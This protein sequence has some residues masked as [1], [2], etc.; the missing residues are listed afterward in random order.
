MSKNKSAVEINH[1]DLFSGIGGFR[2]GLEQAGFGFKN[3]FHSEVD[4]YANGV[5][6]KQ[7]LQSKE[8]GDVKKIKIRIEESPIRETSAGLLLPHGRNGAAGCPGH[9][10]FRSAPVEN[11]NGRFG[12]G[13][14]VITCPSGTYV[15]QGH[16]HAITFGWPCQDN[17]IAGKR[18]GQKGHT[19]SGLLREAVRIV[20]SALPDYFIAENVGGLYSIHDGCGYYETIRMLAYLGHGLPQYNIEMQFLDTGWFLPQNRKR[21]YFVGYLATSGGNRP[22]VFPIGEGSQVHREAFQKQNSCSSSIRPGMSR[23]QD[24]GVS[25]I[26]DPY[27]KSIP[28][29]QKNATALR[30]NYSNHNAMVLSRP[31]GFNKGGVKCYPNV[32]QSQNHNELVLLNKSQDGK[33]VTPDDH[34]FSLSA[35]HYNKPKLIYPDGRLKDRNNASTLNCGAHSAGNHSGMDLLKYSGRIRRLTPTECCRLQGF[36]DD[37]LGDIS[38]SQ[39]YKCLGNAVSVTVVRA[40]GQKLIKYFN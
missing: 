15:V 10:R 40:I 24:S 4:H 1:L 39:K 26:I 30:T 20:G 21:I 19:R 5:Y 6:K 36:P 8:L 31:H 37:W 7:F 35:G 9:S 25:F 17:S 11:K 14:T 22:K 29:D 27:N 38:D 12:P 2:L 18:Q 33:V 3:E 23:V 28:A 34:S 16:I 13:K 32:R